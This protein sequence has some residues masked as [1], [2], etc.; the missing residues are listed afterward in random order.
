[1][2]GVNSSKVIAAVNHVE[3]ASRWSSGSRGFPR[4]LGSTGMERSDMFAPT[5][6]RIETSRFSG[7][8]FSSENFRERGGNCVICN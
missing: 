1:M 2:Q 5:R 4:G 6:E 8:R 3:K 7:G